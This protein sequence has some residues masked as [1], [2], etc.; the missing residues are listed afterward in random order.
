MRQLNNK[1]S[2]NFTI[3]PIDKYNIDGDFIESQAFAYLS[4]RSILKIPISF[5]KTTGCIAPVSGGDVIEIK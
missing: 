5:P 3:E 4:I 2:K 1:T